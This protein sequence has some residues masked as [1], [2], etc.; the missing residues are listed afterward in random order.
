[1]AEPYYIT[2]AISY[3][4]GRPHIGHA[5][6][7]IAADA[8]ARFRRS[9]GRDV[10]FVTGTDEHGLKMIQTARAEGRDTL[11]FADE[12]SGYFRDMCRELNISY[13]AF[14]RTSEPR[15]YEA[16]AAIW[17]AMEAAGDL[18]LDRYEGWY[19]VR[20]EAF[21][22][23]SELIEGEGGE[24]LSPQGTP[25]DWTA[26]ETWF[27]RLSKYQEPLLALYRDNPDFIR[28]ESRCNEVTRFV[29]GGLK[30]L[31]VSRTS[32]DWGVPV[33]GSPGHVMYVWVDALTTY[34]TGV[35]FP[36]RE[37]E[38][39][40]FWP[41]DVHL[42]GKD[43]VRFHAV[44]WPAFLMSAG[45][46]LPRQVF[47]HGFILARGGEKMSK[48]LGNVVDPLDM[49]EQYGVDALRYF[50]LREVSF[51]QDGSYS[52][53]AIVN[54]VNSELANSFGNLAQRSLSMIFKNLYGIIPAP[55][56]AEE[57]RALLGQVTQACDELAKEFD[58]FAFS[59]GLE[60][61]MGAVFACNA[62]IDA[63]APWALKKSDPAR[64]AAVLG[65]LV[66]AVRQLAEAV[67]PVIP[68]SAET[69]IALIDSGMDGTPISQPV[70]IFPRLE[71]GEEEAA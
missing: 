43:I 31:S 23:E 20:D 56:E 68:G 28:P 27:F 4:N 37:G 67:A 44:Y 32:F 25:V 12:M 49:A 1:M 21:Y 22:D 30:D 70:P 39:D 47:G 59:I 71:I 36:E 48:S 3:P 14:V 57:D 54:R 51:G 15:H 46:P 35:G 24:K 18:Y 50:L 58:R 66:V 10:R 8:M 34:M 6:E 55:G 61:W 19:S 52:H 2:T 29:E 65:T 69:L 16:S 7:A 42:I 38:F 64:M 9:Q 33:P 53:E 26:E 13:D 45:L 62:Y 11:E 40:R 5:Y 60:A 63:A 17:K 41:A